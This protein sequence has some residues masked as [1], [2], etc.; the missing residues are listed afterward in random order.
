M[1]KKKIRNKYYLNYLLRKFYL[2]ESKNSIIKK[3]YCDNFIIFY[4]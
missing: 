4:Y 3:F 2:L 1:K